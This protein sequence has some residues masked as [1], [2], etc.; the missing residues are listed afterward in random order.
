MITNISNQNQFAKNETNKENNNKEKLDKK[1]SLND[2]LKNPLFLKEESGVKLPKDYVSKIDQ[3]L[4]ELLNKLLDQIK[5]DKD[6]NLAVLKNHKDLNFAPNLANELKK[7]QNE[8]SKNP[9]FE[10]L[11][12]N[13]EELIK[14]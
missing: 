9:E 3:K 11:F 2:V 13:L 14:P 4:Q 8:L 1:T 12:Q 6:S 5:T 7:L 10:K